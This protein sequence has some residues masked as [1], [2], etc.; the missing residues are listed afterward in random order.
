M[1]RYPSPVRVVETFSRKLKQFGTSVGRDKN[2]RTSEFTR[3]P[4]CESP[5]TRTRLGTAA[6][7]SLLYDL[8]IELVDA[9]ILEVMFSKE[10]VIVRQTR[11]EVQIDTNNLK[12]IS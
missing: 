8:L 5:C 7:D 9:I 1:Y 12:Q 3:P 2:Q 11:R 4:Y 6:S 10:M